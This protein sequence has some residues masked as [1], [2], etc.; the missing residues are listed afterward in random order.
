MVW[1]KIRT[2]S[3]EWKV[4]CRDQKEVEMERWLSYLESL[5]RRPLRIKGA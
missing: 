4:L 3:I 1:R 2:L 5:M